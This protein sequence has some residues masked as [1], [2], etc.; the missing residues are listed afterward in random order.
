MPG[1]SGWPGVWRRALAGGALWLACA[2]GANFGAAQTNR[3]WNGS[4]S[5]DWFNPANWTPTGVPSAN[6]TVNFNNGTINPTAPVTIGG[7][8]N[9]SGGS[10]AGSPLT[11]ATNG[12]LN[13]VGGG[14][15]TLY[16]P[17]TNAGTINWSNSAT[18]TLYNNQSASYSGAIYNLSGAR[19]NIQSDQGMNGAWGNEFF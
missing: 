2:V 15:V 7:Q 14:S 3:T 9:W 13:V 8:F 12:V 19:L 18:W 6:D 5:S 4:A 16:A 11:I 10:L 17:L 1:V